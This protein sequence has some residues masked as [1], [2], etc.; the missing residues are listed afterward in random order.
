MAGAIAG[1]SGRENFSN[2][3]EF[4]CCD[5]GFQIT[6]LKKHPKGAVS[7]KN[8]LWLDLNTIHNNPELGRDSVCRAEDL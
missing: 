6:L 5:R 1:H 2:P 8:A 4:T 7:W 3:N